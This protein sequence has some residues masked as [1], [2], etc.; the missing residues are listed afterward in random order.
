MLIRPRLLQHY[1]K[2]EQRS[3]LPFLTSYFRGHKEATHMGHPR[4]GQ[5]IGPYVSAPGSSALL[6]GTSAVL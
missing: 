4:M 1:L 2:A 6:Q 3:R 5:F